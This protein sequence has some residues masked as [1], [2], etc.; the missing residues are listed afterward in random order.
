[1]LP[2]LIINKKKFKHNLDHILNVAH[3][4]GLTIMVVTKVFSADQ[5]LVD[6]INL[7]SAD[8][9]ADSRI[10]NL[11]SMKTDKEKVLLRIPSIS[12]AQDVITYSDIS[13]NSELKTIEYLNN[14]AIENNIIHKV[15][16]ML[17]LGDLREGI[18]YIDELLKTVKEVIKLSNIVLAGIGTNLTCYGGVIPSATIYDKLL[19]IK[20]EIVNNFGI[21]LQII[22][23][24]NSSSLDMLL[25]RK[26]P[27]GINNL[28]IGEAIVLGRETAYGD[29]LDNM[30]NDVFTLEAEIVELK[31]KPSIPIG[32]IGM[33]A[34]GKTPKFDDL[35]E[36][37]RGIIS[38]GKQD[39][40]H[41]E[42][43]P[44][45]TIKILGSSS[46]HIILNMNDTINHY[47]IG[48]T[49]LFKLSYSSLLSLNTSKYISK[50]YV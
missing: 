23:G 40:D 7:S 42:I 28:R 37:L 19:N 34:F 49:V 13:L 38:I 31:L 30:Y 11:K 36:I 18:F 2:K 20:E 5:N 45:D 25:N 48:D 35:G 43:I 12:E 9:I 14:V 22:S 24:G 33:N 3:K 44:F 46:D 41:N 4:Q 32:E 17:D 15:I 16:L 29:Y 26:L 8:Y 27:K 10:E 6:I 1:M 39:V 47:E 50:H 21:S